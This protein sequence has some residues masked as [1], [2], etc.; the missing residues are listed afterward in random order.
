VNLAA[1]LAC[2]SDTWNPRIIGEV[3]DVQV[4]VVKLKGAFEW[5]HHADEDEMFLILHGRMTM[6]F[7][8]RDVLLD[9]GDMLVV[10]RGVEHLPI[11][12]EECGVL[13]VEP[14]TTLN[15]GNITSDRT[16]R[17]LERLA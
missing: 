4:K 15:T 5:H 6:R 17:Q 14:R 11:A 1:A 2:F 7:R 3:N 8:D 10:P 9:A 16:R 13:L 12:D